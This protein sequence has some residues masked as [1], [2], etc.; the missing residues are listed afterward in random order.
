[1]QL[2]RDLYDGEV[3]ADD[4]SLGQ[5][6]KQIP[7][8]DDAVVIVIADHGEAFGDHHNLSHGLDLYTETLRVPLV[9]K[10]PK[11]EHAG[12][13]IENQASLIDLYPTLAG[14]A[15][16]EKPKYLE[17]G[18]LSPLWSGRPMPERMLFAM[19][20]RAPEHVWYSALGPRYKFLFFDS[21][22]RYEM[23]DMR[24]DPSEQSNIIKKQHDLAQDYRRELAEERRR[25][26]LFNPSVVG[27]PMSDELR[28]A[29]HQLGYL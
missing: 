1:M 10:L 18:D 20:Q 28:N 27:A 13:V 6:L 22:N 4:D 8:L 23:Y 29:L 17:G 11:N 7:A 3:M 25:S 2:I 26:P 5:L 9:F 12:L 14:L 21:E 15:G 24:R 19:T 16:A